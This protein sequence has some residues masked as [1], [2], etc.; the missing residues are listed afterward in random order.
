MPVHIK[1]A[2]P[3]DAAAIAALSSDVQRLHADAYPRR[4]KQPVDD[5]TFTE[6]LAVL[7]QNPNSFA[8]LARD[9][10]APVGYILAEIIRRSETLRL[11]AHE[12]IYVHHMSVR[13]GSQRKGIGGS[14]LDACKAKGR[15]LGISLLAL[16]TWS[17][18]DPALAFFHKSGLT[19]LSVRLSSKID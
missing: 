8:Y 7:L 14:L 2:S 3:A 16:D 17:F 9:H 15:S 13:P 12:M 10:D 1:E 5:K 18:N 6:E 4:F 11:L 19:P